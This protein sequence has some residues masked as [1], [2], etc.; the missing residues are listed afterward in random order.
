MYQNCDVV[1]K[2]QMEVY[3]IFKD[4]SIVSTI[5]EKGDI[6]AG[7]VYTETYVRTRVFASL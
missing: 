4:R 1:Y 6:H 7:G 3:I 5:T 2:V